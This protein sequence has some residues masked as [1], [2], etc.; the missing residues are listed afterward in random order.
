M[1]QNDAPCSN[2]LTVLRFG[3]NTNGN[4]RH[5][6]SVLPDLGPGRMGG[7][8]LYLV[9]TGG[10]RKR[11]HADQL[12]KATNALTLAYQG[13]EAVQ[14]RVLVGEESVMDELWPE[15]IGCPWPG[16]RGEWRQPCPWSARC[17]RHTT[18]VFAA[19]RKH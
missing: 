1:E 15:M 6:A 3:S 19:E 14:V 4:Q 17:G 12:S 5:L 16:L 2:V 11:P 10:E 9:R 8:R 18:P 7:P 13:F